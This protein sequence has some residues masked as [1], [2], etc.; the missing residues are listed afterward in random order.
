MNP[1]I[2]VQSVTKTISINRG[3][4]PTPLEQQPFY[5]EENSVNTLILV[6]NS[7]NTIENTIDVYSISVEKE[8][9]YSRILTSSFMDTF[10]K[11]IETIPLDISTKGVFLSDGTVTNTVVTSDITITEF[12]ISVGSSYFNRTADYDTL[13]EDSFVTLSVTEIPFDSNTYT[14]IEVQIQPT[15]RYDLSGGASLSISGDELTAT[16]TGQFATALW[17]IND[18]KASGG[19]FYVELL[20]TSTYAMFAGIQTTPT[21]V[22]NYHGGTGSNGNGGI[23]IGYINH[24][25]NEWFPIL[26][27][28]S[29]GQISFNNEPFQAFPTDGTADPDLFLGLYDASSGATGSGTWNFG[30]TAFALPVP[31]G[32]IPLNTTRVTID[33]D[34]SNVSLLL[35][36]EKRNNN[37]LFFKDISNNSHTVVPSGNVVISSESA[38]F[39]TYSAYFDGQTGSHLRIDNTAEIQITEGTPFSLEL[40]FLT[41]D[42]TKNQTLISKNEQEGVSSVEYNIF[43]NNITQGIEAY[44]GDDLVSIP[45]PPIISYPGISFPNDGYQ[46]SEVI[47][48]IDYFRSDS[49]PSS[50]LSLS[51]PLPLG[52]YYF[53]VVITTMTHV[54]M[55]FGLA[56]SS[57]TGGYSTSPGP[58][59]VYGY[60]GNIFPA[61]TA[62]ISAYNVGSRLMIAYN[63]TTREVWF[64]LNGVWGQD[65]TQ[66]SSY[67]VAGEAGTNMAI[68]LGSGTNSN[69]IFRAT[70]H[71]ASAD[72]IYSVP[73][74]FTSIGDALVPDPL[75]ATPT[76]IIPNTWNYLALVYN[77]ANFSF[78]VNGLQEGTSV[79]PSSAIPNSI[80]PLYI[81]ES[82]N[83]LNKQ[84]LEGYIDEVRIVKNVTTRTDTYSLF[85]PFFKGNIGYR[86]PIA[87]YI[88]I[89]TIEKLTSVTP[90]IEDTI[91]TNISISI[92]DNN[93]VRDLTI[94]KFL[95]ITT[96]EFVSTKEYT[97]GVIFTPIDT[98]ILV[99]ESKPQNLSV[100]YLKNTFISIEKDLLTFSSVTPFLAEI[101]IVVPDITELGFFD[102][103]GVTYFGRAEDF[104]P[105]T[106]YTQSGSYE[107]LIDY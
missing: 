23:Y 74:G 83:L 38:F 81:G 47:N 56:P 10:V 18:A 48:E 69:L 31:E 14:Y 86:R 68:S 45:P 70:V 33:E 40:A 100:T 54:A 37:S 85:H 79:T 61:N 102:I 60:N 44:V 107:V 25:L 13:L 20:S 4:A 95:D 72:L 55:M 50:G 7:I 77:G 35:D 41:Q 30:G 46:T 19:K 104:I 17:D 34:F 91:L 103:N 29:S 87:E 39:E 105:D 57:F 101:A 15:Y 98:Q 26:L 92:E 84:S 28:F 1:S 88:N 24:P 97:G 66:P 6:K 65:P 11:G 89:T 93:L 99:K 52:T 22:G 42:A 94:N 75:A 76:R 3:T 59:S 5:L 49:T 82:P 80:E 9:E 21:R 78:F 43:Y 32:Y 51:D 12:P 53:E 67:F 63:T 96:K 2:D 71:T 73:T 90:P 36:M 62:Y 27:D 58:Q 106:G 8:R 64:G 16:S